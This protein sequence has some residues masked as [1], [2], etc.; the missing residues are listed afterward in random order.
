MWVYVLKTERNLLPTAMVYLVFEISVHARNVSRHLSTVTAVF[1]TAENELYRGT[2]YILK[3]NSLF[4]LLKLKLFLIIFKNSVRT[5][6]RTLH[7]TITKTN[8]LM[9]FKEIIAVYTE[10]RTILIYK[11][12]S[13]S[14]LKWWV[15]IVTIRLQKVKSNP[16]LKRLRVSVNT[17]T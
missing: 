8:W 9:T 5:S 17:P 1:P 16:T 3:A 12:R 14:R 6:K 13:Y 7:F 10:N 11:K 15:R 4:N 2:I